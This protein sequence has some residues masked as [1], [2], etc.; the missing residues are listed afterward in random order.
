MSL[1]C[2]KRCSMTKT[3]THCGLMCSQSGA[4]PI[5]VQHWKCVWL[6]HWKRPWNQEKKDLFECHARTADPGV[7]LRGEFSLALNLDLLSGAAQRRAAL[8]FWQQQQGCF[9]NRL[10]EAQT[11]VYHSDSQIL[12]IFVHQVIQRINRHFDRVQRGSFSWNGLW[13]SVK[14][15]GWTAHS[16]SSYKPLLQMLSVLS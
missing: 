7:K 14:T 1:W 6:C 16:V 5:L 3:E 13:Q 12:P 10:L 9:C 15:G 2:G 8:Q 4:A 11:A